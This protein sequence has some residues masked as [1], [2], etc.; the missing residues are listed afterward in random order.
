MRGGPGRIS[1]GAKQ[2]VPDAV[3]EGHMSKEHGHT[4]DPREK[5]TMKEIHHA[6]K[7]NHRRDQAHMEK[8]DDY[9]LPCR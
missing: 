8:D 7:K 5:E 3:A 6:I 9:S 2:G 1:T 4:P